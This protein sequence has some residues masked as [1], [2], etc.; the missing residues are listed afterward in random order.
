MGARHVR[1]CPVGDERQMEA[2]Q[3]LAVADLLL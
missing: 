2:E 1:G 3:P